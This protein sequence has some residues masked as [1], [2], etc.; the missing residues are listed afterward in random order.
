[1]LPPEAEGA[2]G[3]A[4]EAAVAAGGAGAAGADGGG[5]AGWLGVPGRLVGVVGI[6]LATVEGVMLSD[7][8]GATRGPR[9]PRKRPATMAATTAMASV[10]RITHGHTWRREPVESCELAS[11]AAGTSGAV[12]RSVTGT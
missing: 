4:V 6:A 3:A 8:D 11:P 12:G 5:G 7:G 2:E 1:M 10:A 9:L